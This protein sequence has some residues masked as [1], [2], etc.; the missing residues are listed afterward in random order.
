MATRPAIPRRMEKRLYQEVRSKCPVCNEPDISKLTIHHIMPFANVLTH[1][2]HNMICLC[3]NCHAKAGANEI[4]PDDLFRLKKAL[5]IS[6]MQGQKTTVHAE[7]L[8]PESILTVAG[9]IAAGR[10][11]VISGPIVINKNTVSR[12]AAPVV[13][14]TIAT[15]SWRS[16]YLENLVTRYNKFKKD[17]RKLSAGIWIPG[18]RHTSG[19]V[20]GRGSVVARTD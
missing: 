17:Q 15:D 8:K 4:S 1:D 7:P 20:S 6:T 9:I 19:T 3:A 13:M 10:D 16:G 18:Q 11:N 14:G 5:S 2:E 12:R